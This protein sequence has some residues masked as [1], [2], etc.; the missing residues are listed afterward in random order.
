M[1]PVLVA[2]VVERAGPQIDDL[3]TP[4]AIAVDAAAAIAAPSGCWLRRS[5]LAAICSRSTAS[6]NTIAK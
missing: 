5:T 6:E 1:V 2:R 4:G 3:L